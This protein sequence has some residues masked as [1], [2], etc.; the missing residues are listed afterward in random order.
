[1]DG[2]H[3]DREA[4]DPP[5]A[6]GEGEF[7]TGASVGHG[8]LSGV[9]FADRLVTFSSVDGQALFEGDIVLDGRITIIEEVG[10]TPPAAAEPDVALDMADEDRTLAGAVV[11]TGGQ[12]RWPNGIVPFE[13]DS[14]LPQA[15]QT[16]VTDALN[17]WRSRTRL[18]FPQHSQSDSNWI[19]FVSG[20]GCSS[21]VGRQGGR[22]DIT[23][24]AGCG[25]G[26]AIHEIGHAVGLWHEQSR[27]D[28]DTFV[29][30]FWQNIDPAQRH[31]FDQHITDGDDVGEYDYGSIMHYPTWAFSINGQDTIEPKQAGVTIGQR[32]GLSPF[33]TAGVRSIYPLLQAPTDRT[34]VGDFTGDGQTDLLAYVPARLNWWLGSATAGG[35]LALHDVGSTAGFGQVGDGRPFWIG[36]F[37]APDRDEILFYYPGDDNWWLGRFDGSTLG[38]RLVSNTRGFGHA[39]NDG[40]PFWIADFNG[41]GK[42]EVLFYYPGDDNWWIAV[43]NGQAFVWSFAG[44]TRGF[45]HAINDGRPF[46]IGDFNGDG[47]AEVLFYFPGDDNW[48]LGTFNGTT[49]TWSHV[50]NTIGFGHAINDGRPFWIGRFS[51]PDRDEVLFYFPGDDNWWLGRMTGAALSW[52]PAGNTRGFGHGI[53]DGRPFWIG[54]FDGDARSEV[55]FYFPGDRNWWRAAHNGSQLAWSLAGNTTGFGQ[56]WDGRPFWIGRF[57]L[58]GHD[59]VLFYYPHDGK[60]WLATLAAPQFGWRMFGDF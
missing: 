27:E 14:G 51:H 9:T 37:S 38:W 54:D 40:R 7:R 55:L 4:G 3:D 5:A 46:W 53:Y 43:D 47:K 42:S 44:N 13:V 1:M 52:S 60:Y 49:L 18:S 19:R 33:D 34:F 39:I 57:A 50:G 10:E 36:R 45:G 21:Q 6:V 48:W 41:D 58:A 28:R 35:Q 24:G 59:N 12:Y 2:A 32:S 23:L 31:N 29:T 26:Q 15:Q 25:T 11:V 8:Y 22:Q 56:I 17:H 16:A 30:I 20:S